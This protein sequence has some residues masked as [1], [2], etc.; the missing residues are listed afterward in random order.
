MGKLGEG[1]IFG[2]G[3]VMYVYTLIAMIHFYAS[4]RV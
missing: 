1:C 2:F 3:L 4:C